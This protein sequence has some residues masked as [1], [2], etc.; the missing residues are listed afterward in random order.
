RKDAEIKLRLEW[1]HEAQKEELLLNP[2]Q[3]G[4][5]YCVLASANCSPA[6]ISSSLAVPLDRAGR[7]KHSNLVP[8][9]VF[10]KRQ[11][12]IFIFF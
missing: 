8:S 9:T 10:Q 4:S 12:A 7:Y 1:E 5:G 2:R 6:I 11:K 3:A